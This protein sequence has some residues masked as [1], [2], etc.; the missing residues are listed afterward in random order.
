MVLVILAL[1]WAAAL[2]P[3]FVRSR[4]EG[5]PVDSIGR[6]RRHLRVLECTTP[7]AN[8]LASDPL[9]ALGPHRMPEAWASEARRLRRLRRRRRTAGTLL[10]AMLGSLV[11]SAI[12]GLHQL[13]AFHLLL[14]AAFVAYLALLAQVKNQES[15]RRLDAEL[16]SMLEAEPEYQSFEPPMVREQAF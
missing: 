10:S 16:V 15:A 7:A 11:V 13:L 2:L 3:P 12:P 4:L 14:D 5:D 1:I 6:F 9:V 8:A